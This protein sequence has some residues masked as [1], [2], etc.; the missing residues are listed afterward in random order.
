MSEYR[1]HLD[2]YNGPLD[3]LLYLIRRD[4]VDIH[5]IPIARITEQ[6]VAYVEMLQELD[7]NLAG[8]FLVMAATLM[9]IKTR[10]LL[11]AAP[12]EEGEGEEFG[13]DPRADLVRQ[14]LQYKAFKD[15][16]D[17]LGEAA[18]VQAQRFARRPAK[19]DFSDEKEFDLDEVQIWDLFDAFRGVM[20]SIG[21]LSR[22]HEVIY[23]DTP[24]ELHA[25]DILHRLRTDGAMTFSKIF[26]G[27]TQKT[28]LV[29]LF[30]AVLELIRLKKIL[31]VQEGNF[32]EIAIEL[33]PN[34]PDENEEEELQRRIAESER[35][36]TESDEDSPPPPPVDE[37]G[38]D[39]D[40]EDE[41]DELDRIVIP[42]IDM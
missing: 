41:D 42:E 26:E 31:A 1:V 40:E 19:I 16:A 5:D 22:Q 8:E 6:Y 29:G 34:P 37:A 17:D 36:Q 18:D 32:A 23:D 14:L 3:L 33:N 12:I 39:E 35:H 30:I 15:A 7:P 28:E 4:E 27:R 21:N 10:M 38:D 2:I 11:P 24:V 25:E 13:I 20:D 9:E